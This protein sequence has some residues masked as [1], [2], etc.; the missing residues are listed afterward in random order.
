MQELEAVAMS[1]SEQRLVAHGVDTVGPAKVQV[2]AFFPQVIQTY[3]IC[4]QIC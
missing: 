3:F 1:D 2:K 4:M